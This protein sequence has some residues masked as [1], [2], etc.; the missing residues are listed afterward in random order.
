MKRYLDLIPISARIHKKQSRMTRIC[1]ILAVF[2]VTAIFSMADME[3]RSQYLQTIQSDGN[4]HAMFRQINEED[5]AI[6]AARPEVEATS[7]Y[8]VLNY[9]ADEDYTINGEKALICGFEEGFYQL[10]PSIRILESTGISSTSIEH[11]VV[12]TENAREKLQVQ[13]GETLEL[14][15]PDG[16]RQK[17]I[18]CGF[19]NA[20]GMIMEED[21]VGLFTSMETFAEMAPK[22]EADQNAYYVQFYSKCNIPDVISDIEKS[23]GLSEDQ[24]SRNEKLLGVMGMSRDSYILQ[25]YGVAAVLA[26][27]VITAGVLMIASNLNSQIARRIEFFGMMRCLGATKKQVKRFVRFEALNWC[28]YALPIGCGGGIVIT[29]CLCALLRALSPG[30]FASMPII[31]ISW[32]GVV[33]GIV[34]GLVTV[35]I[36]ASAP[37]KRA[38]QVSPLTAVYGNSGQIAGT[39]ITF[40]DQRVTNRDVKGGFYSMAL[41]I[42]GFLIIIA[43][44]SSFN[45]INSISMSVSARMKQYG[46]MRAIGMSDRQLIKMVAAESVTYAVCGILFGGILGIPMH[47]FLYEQMITFRWGDVWTFPV[48]PAAVIILT[49]GLSTILA[50]CG[51]VKRIREMTIVNTIHGE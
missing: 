17:L 47:K 20:P 16:T 3:I 51:P 23:L 11:A 25:L 7:W 35:L 33:S 13:I 30:Y 27:L 8:N 19:S 14:K 46:A 21:A 37:A 40:S 45:I 9:Q 1:I 22:N 2:L 24:V 18:V 15:K 42:Y 5:A 50:V 32:L 29:W 44:I 36:A 31:G 38:S 43:L 6:I 26:V 10:M 28:K 34:I 41:F 12:L 49:I 48:K 4:W 39:D